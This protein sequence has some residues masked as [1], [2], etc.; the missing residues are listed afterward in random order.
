MMIYRCHQLPFMN[1]SI[2]LEEQILIYFIYGYSKV[3]CK[4]IA[5]TKETKVIISFKWDN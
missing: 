3:W 4:A 1:D 2:W 5:L